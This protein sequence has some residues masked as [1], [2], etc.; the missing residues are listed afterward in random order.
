MKKPGLDAASVM[1][2]GVEGAVMMM[3]SLKLT[4]MWSP[5]ERVRNCKVMV[6]TRPVK[7]GHMDKG[8]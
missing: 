4:R 7:V 3:M 8:S 6:W 2:D 5:G 1:C